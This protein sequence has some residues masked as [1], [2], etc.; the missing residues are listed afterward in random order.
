MHW[1]QHCQSGGEALCREF[2][3]STHWWSVFFLNDPPMSRRPWLHRPACWEAIDAALGEK[4]AHT[5]FHHRKHTEE[6][7]VTLT[8]TLTLCAHF[9]PVAP[10][11]Y[12][13]YT[14]TIPVLYR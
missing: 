12:R 5:L 4:P 13:Y 6:Y 9:R 2:C 7:M 14:G 3:A 8:L 11:F 10:A 1:G